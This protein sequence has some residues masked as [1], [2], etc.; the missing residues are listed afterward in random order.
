MVD[1]LGLEYEVL[2]THV[3]Y[4][5]HDMADEVLKRKA[6][7]AKGATLATPSGRTFTGEE[8]EHRLYEMRCLVVKD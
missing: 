3:D 2:L 1:Y 6:L 5:R 4:S 8:A 7:I